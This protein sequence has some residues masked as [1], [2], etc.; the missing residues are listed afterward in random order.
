LL[1]H[2]TLRYFFSLR[3]NIR[4]STLQFGTEIDSFVRNLDRFGYFA[5]SQ[6]FSSPGEAWTRRPSRET[7]IPNFAPRRTVETGSPKKDAISCQPLSSAGCVDF[8]IIFTFAI[9]TVQ[10]LYKNGLFLA[11][12]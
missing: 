8:G 11:V 12:S 6:R 5:P 4:Q 7:G 2:H 1:L 3:P 9:W 10:G